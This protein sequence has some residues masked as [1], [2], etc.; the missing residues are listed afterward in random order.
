L[1]PFNSNK[2]RIGGRAEYNLRLVEEFTLHG[3]REKPTFGFMKEEDGEAFKCQDINKPGTRAALA[4]R[5]HSAERFPPS[6][7]R[8][9]SAER[10]TAGSEVFAGFA[11]FHVDC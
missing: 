9:M 1:L 11:L 8:Q 5:G 3:W 4:R 10:R 7:P 6:P 2:E